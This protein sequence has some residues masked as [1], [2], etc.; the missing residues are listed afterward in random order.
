MPLYMA[1]CPGRLRA[2]FR[3]YILLMPACQHRSSPLPFVTWHAN[4]EIKLLINVKNTE[5]QFLNVPISLL[6]IENIVLFKELFHARPMVLHI[7]V[8]SCKITYILARVTLLK[9]ADRPQ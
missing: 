4:P 9:A 2:T 8:T 6:W 3:F 7:S 5:K 1:V